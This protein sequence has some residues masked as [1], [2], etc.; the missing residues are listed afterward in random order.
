MLIRSYA[1]AFPSDRRI[2]RIDRWAVPV[3]G[4]LPLAASAWYLAFALATFGLSQLPGL[5]LIAGVVGWPALMLIGPG[6]AAVFITRRTPDGRSLPSY[7]IAAL[8]WKARPVPAAPATGGG[9]RRMLAA[10][11]FSVRDSR[12][13]LRG[14]GV[15]VLGAARC[16]VHS[17]RVIAVAANDLSAP[18]RV[19]QMR[20][21]DEL[22]V[23]A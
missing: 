7:A 9:E 3:P 5:N 22:E 13:L 1:R 4:G 11:D 6:A 20:H 21:G 2:Y 16:S 18:G 10:A 17:D 23:H 12:T 14:P 19:V 15:I 8:R